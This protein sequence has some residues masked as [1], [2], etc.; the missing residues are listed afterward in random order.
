MN[1]HRLVQYGDFPQLTVEHILRDQFQRNL[2]RGVV[3]GNDLP[4]VIARGR[5]GCA[6]LGVGLVQH[7]S[8]PLRWP[9]EK[10]VADRKAKRA[11]FRM[12]HDVDARPAL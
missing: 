2:E 5:P 11:A 1:L 10:V 8:W 4:V 12:L 7:K 6:R 9:H 3:Q